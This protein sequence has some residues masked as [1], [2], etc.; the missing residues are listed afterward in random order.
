MLIEMKKL[1]QVGVSAQE[2][3]EME[4]NPRWMEFVQ[5]VKGSEYAAGL[6]ECCKKYRPFSSHDHAKP[7]CKRQYWKPIHC[8]DFEYCPVCS[9][10]KREGE[11]VD[12]L[13]IA[14]TFYSRMG[15]MVK[16]AS[17]E[18]TLPRDMQLELSDDNLSDLRKIADKIVQKVVGRGQNLT[19][20]GKSAVQWWHSSNPFLGNYPHVHGV[21][22]S[23]VF[24]EDS[25]ST[26]DDSGTGD[27]RE[28]NLYLSPSQLDE[29]RSE[30]M[31]AIRVYGK[32][33]SKNV[34]VH[35]HV[36]RGY[37]HL[38]HR[39]SY[40]HRSATT[41]FFKYVTSAKFYE[42]GMA[43]PTEEELAW[44][45]RCLERSA[46]NKS[47]CGFGMLAPSR[48]YKWAERA[49]WT[50]PK[51]KMRRMVRRRDGSKCPNCG[52]WMDVDYQYGHTHFAGLPVDACILT[53]AVGDEL[54]PV[55]RDWGKT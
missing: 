3:R 53:Y 7:D 22:Y 40:M 4:Q 49:G 42:E 37:N 16:F 27:F 54:I 34:V 29:L 8:C 28:V 26:L 18:F 43:Q 9:R 14:H 30:W 20:M 51:K 41:D 32:T 10:I 45:K 6:A 12:D 23:L 25:I 38:S 5:A 50:L 15:K 52:V 31:K 35:W 55:L 47:V 36:S 11:A 48:V 24:D 44:I 39:L 1:V 17:W 21:L 2:Y 13:E 46:G 19:F 33:K